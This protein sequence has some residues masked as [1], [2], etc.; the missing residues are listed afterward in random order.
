MSTGTDTG[1]PGLSRVTGMHADTLS[2]SVRLRMVGN[3]IARGLR[4]RWVYRATLV[5]ELFGGV[6][7]FLM[8]QY[9]VGDGRIL[10]DLVAETAPAMLAYV[11]GYGLMMRL[12][13][14]ILE[15]R[16]AGTLEQTHLSPLPA[17][18][19]AAGRLGAA[20]VEM[21]AAGLVVTT[22]VLVIVGVGYPFD[23]QALVPL[24]L[25]LASAAAFALLIAAASFTY[26][27]IG[28]LVHI[29]QM[30]VMSV[31]GMFAPVELYPQWL[32]LFAK[33]VPTTL[34][35]SATRRVL[36]GGDSLADLWGDGALGWLLV[37]T[38][39]LVVAGWVAYQAQIRR[40]LRDGRLGP[41]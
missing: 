13:S 27:G 18:Q 36:I 3:E 2:T 15:E 22:A 40:A 9:F 8:V 21:L 32:E 16:N 5:P 6:A 17:W 23:P 37:H 14:G 39:V 25:T 20:L 33:L 41:A 31:N 4:L 34:G 10:D 12:V 7:M 11:V 24:S 30:L 19:L 38:T 28:A 35:V 26:P 29:V 1:M